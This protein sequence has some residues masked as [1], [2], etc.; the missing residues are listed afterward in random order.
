MGKKATMINRGGEGSP[1]WQMVEE[2]KFI[3][4]TPMST[5]SAP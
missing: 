5:T 2:R 4:K 1:R 3:N